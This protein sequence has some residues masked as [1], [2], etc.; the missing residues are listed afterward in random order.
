MNREQRPDRT[1]APVEF[2]WTPEQDELREQARA[3][4]TDAVAKY[5]RH[6]DSWIN[7][8]SKE[9]AQE[10]A[11]LGWIGLTWPKEFGGRGRPPLDRLIVG[12]E[13][14]SAGAPIAAMW[15]ADRQMGP[16]LIAYGRPDQQEA[17]LP[18]ILS[19]ETTWC[20][21]MSEP[22]A[23]SDLASLVTSAVRDGD[24]YVINGQ[25]IWTSF[26]AVADYCYLSAAPRRAGWPTRGSA[27]SI[28]PMSTPGIEVRP[29][30]DM[31]TN[32]HFCEVFFTD[33]RV[34]AANLVGIEGAAFKQ[35]MGQLEHERGGIDRLM[36]NR[37]LYRLAL[38]AR[39]HVRSTGPPGDRGARDRLPDR[40]H[41]RRPRGAEA[42]PARV[43]GGDQ[44]LLHRARV[45]RRRVRVAGVRRGGHAVER[46]HPRPA[47]R[48]RV[49]DHG[50]HVEHHAQHP[51]RTRTRPAPRAALTV[52]AWP[53]P[54]HDG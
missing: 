3:V 47:L 35:T 4:A 54:S 40:S 51:R 36:S 48:A 25:K 46:R 38:R 5:G 45:A 26:A 50:R 27:S 8:Y 14:I 9:F 20:I 34:P 17:F 11:A 23:G 6:N 42:G 16:S 15:F 33:A 12:E 37:A 18:G 49:H 29:I 32:R 43:L 22:N 53:L 19:G 39:R 30:K 41:P 21:G 13:L 24:E 28:V 31:T 10:L 2:G 1:L 52:R 7:G 44:V